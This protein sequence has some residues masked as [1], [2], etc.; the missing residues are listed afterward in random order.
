MPVWWFFDEAY[1]FLGWYVNLEAPARRWPL[2]IDVHDQA[3]DI[4]VEPD[5]TWVWKDE[6]EFAERTGHPDHWTAE[7]ALAVR[8][9]AEKAVADIE[10]GVFPYDGTHT[11][12]RPDPAWEPTRLPPMW[13]RPR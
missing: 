12:F 4:W 1:A 2:G 6:D 5:R 3:L 8:A 10:A 7:E 11:A 13:D 9:E